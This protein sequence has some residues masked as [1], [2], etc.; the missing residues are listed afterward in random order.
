[1]WKWR[2]EGIDPQTAQREESLFALSNGML[3]WRG[4]YEEGT[5]AGYPTIRGCYLNGFFEREKIR[6]GEIAY[7]YAENSQTMLNVTDSQAIGLVCNGKQLLFG[8]PETL[9][10][11]REL[12][13]RAG[14]VTRETVY[15][16]PG[17][18]RL[19]LCSE[20]LVSLARP[21]VAAVR[22]RLTADTDCTLE[23]SPMLNGDVTNRVVA[24]DPRVGSG[25]K[26]RVLSK[27]EQ[28]MN[29]DEASPAWTFVQRTGNSGLSLGV[30]MACQM[31]GCEAALWYMDWSAGAAYELTLHAGQTAELV[32][33]CAYAWDKTGDEQAL[34]DAAEKAAADAL[35]AGFDALAAEQMDTLADFWEKAGLE[36]EGDDALLL[37][38]RFNL[39]HLFQ[40]AGRDGRANVCAKGLTGEGYEGHYFWDTETYMLPVFDSVQPGIARKL[41]EYRYGILPLARQRAREMGHAVGALYPWRTIDGHEASAYYPAGTAQVHINA[42]IAM[43]VRR[44][45]NCTGD[46][47][48]LDE[49]GAEMLAEISRLYYD[50]GFYDASRGGAFCICGV[51]GPDE[52]NA[53]VDNNTYTNLMAAETMRYTCRV[54]E[55]MARRDPAGYAALRDKLDLKEYEMADWK[56]AARRMFVPRDGKTP[57]IWQDD[58]F[59]SRVPW[60]LESIPKENFPLLLHYHPLVIYRHQV[61]K[62]ADLVLAMLLLPHR[63]T[64]EEKRA[65]FDFYDRVTTHDSSLSHAAFSA[66]ASRIGKLDKAY[67]YFRDSAVLDLEDTHGNTADGLHMANMA[68]SWFCLATGFG[69][70]DTDGELL[71]LDPV[72]PE[73]LTAYAFRVTWHGT[74]VEVRV[75]REGAEYARV[76]GPEITIL[77]SGER[78]VL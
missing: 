42:D 34:A 23:I 32:K 35:S 63:F 39:F 69:G 9:E 19:T 12:D 73:R 31:P 58:A 51:T 29:E 22:W 7:G 74:T 48:F 5:A 46:I 71:S 11:R 70:L 50:L 16:I 38:M 17:G 36:I 45:V 4:N 68:G 6:Y 1:M 67:D 15:A 78:V 3:G 8:G 57:L 40:A 18:G 21:G 14:A 61:C 52:Y 55:D 41:L 75:T 2:S 26:G 56:C 33:T 49:M 30:S 43:A 27:P 60:P 44:Y 72:L 37:G 77:A 76:S 54:L 65:A 28:W 24:D 53:L 62:Q 66:L 10:S 64:L 25:L 20:R 59:E 47:A 13:M